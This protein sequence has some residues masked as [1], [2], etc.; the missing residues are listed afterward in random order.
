MAVVSSGQY[1]S[2]ANS[3]IAQTVTHHGHF[4]DGPKLCVPAD[5]RRRLREDGSC[6]NPEAT[7][8]ATITVPKNT[9]ARPL[10]TMKDNAEDKDEGGGASDDL[11][12]DVISSRNF[13]QY[14]EA[15]THNAVQRSD[16]L[17]EF[18]DN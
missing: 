12:G 5:K 8:P 9:D 11:T 16:P 17:Y 7:N 14:R 6:L 18:L 1:F 2:P 13:Y 4:P 3:A 10:Q 15:G